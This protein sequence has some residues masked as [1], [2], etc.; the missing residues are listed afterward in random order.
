MAF[1]GSAMFSQMCLGTIGRSAPGRIL[2]VGADCSK[3]MRTVSG[4]STSAC[5]NTGYSQTWWL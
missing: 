4:S 5:L 2:N 3:V 1:W